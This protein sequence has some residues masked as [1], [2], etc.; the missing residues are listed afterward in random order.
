MVC[1][2]VRRTAAICIRSRETNGM[3]NNVSLRTKLL[4]FGALSILS[5]A[6]VLAL[7]FK[8]NAEISEVAARECLALSSSDLD[9]ILQGT[10]A[11]CATQHESAQQILDSGLKI[12]RKAIDRK[13]TR[14]NSSH[15]CI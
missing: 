1:F 14:L 5:Q 13:S 11:T 4:A 2:A 6:I 15:R 9:H 3:F 10:Y 12:G 7:I 8:A